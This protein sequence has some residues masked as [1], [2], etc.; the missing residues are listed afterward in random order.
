ME[1][2]QKLMKACSSLGLNL[3]EISK[4]VQVNEKPR[5]ACWGYDTVKKESF[6]Y[7]N[8]KVLTYPVEH[9]RLIL[10]HE[11]LHY[12][13]Y[14]SIERVKDFERANIAYDV[15][16]NKILTIAQEKEMI[17]LC[18]KIYS[19]SSKHN[20]LCLVRP[21]LNSSELKN[22]KSLWLEIWKTRE[23]PSPVSIY[24]QLFKPA[25][26]NDNPFGIVNPGSGKILFRKDLA[27]IQNGKFDRLYSGIANDVLNDLGNKGYS[28]VRLSQAFKELFVNKKSFDSSS[29]EEFIYRLESRQKL[30]EISSRII[31]ALTTNSTKQLYP[32]ELSRIGI[33]Y[34]ACGISEKLPIFWNKTPESRKSRLAIYVDTSPSMEGYQEKEIF[35]IGRLKDYFPAKIYCFANDIEEI[36]VEE[37]SQGHYLEGYST[38]FDE[39][40]KHLV[41]SD[42]DA[43]VVFTD[44]QSSVDPENKEKFRESRKRLFTVYFGCDGNN[45]DLNGLSEQTLT[46]KD[47]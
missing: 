35:L 25:E 4:F 47:D 43:G 19:E 36:S 11:I 15:V 28:A 44:G 33:I 31:S 23:I 32:Y 16:I 2:S 38:S 41:D 18:R 29:V 45:C 20:I 13:G 30:E 8:P 9:I 5:I 17:E 39:V 34:V 46:I 1:T 7:V 14:H 26:T 24:Y 27:F 37:L 6:I 10:K 42:F 21:D 3:L 40:I 12:A 22:L